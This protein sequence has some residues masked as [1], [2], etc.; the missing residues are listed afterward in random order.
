[1]DPMKATARMASAIRRFIIE[2]PVFSDVNFSRTTDT[3]VGKT[4]ESG[5]FGPD[6]RL[7]EQLVG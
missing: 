2:A 5:L 1:M 4:P 7:L 3:V 6:F